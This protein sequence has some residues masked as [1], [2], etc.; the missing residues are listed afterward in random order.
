M[1]RKPH[2]HMHSLSLL[3]SRCISDTRGEEIR[4]LEKKEASIQVEKSK[5]VKRLSEKERE[6]KEK[7][8]E[9]TTAEVK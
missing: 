7:K 6:L 4:R 2:K 3:L 1:K 5:L 8:E 9:L